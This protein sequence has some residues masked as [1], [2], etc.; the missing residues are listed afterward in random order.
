[1]TKT[2]KRKVYLSGAMRGIPDLNYPAFTHAQR[3]V[4]AYFDSSWVIVNPADLPSDTPAEDALKADY[5]ALVE[6]DAIAF[7]PNWHGSEGARTEYAIARSLGLKPLFLIE[8]DGYLYEVVET[9]WSDADDASLTPAED[10]AW[11][12]V[13]GKRGTD[14]GPPTRDFA[15]T[16]KMWSGVL[17]VDVTPVQVA[18][19]MICLKVSRL[20]ESN[21]HIDS[22]IDL[23]GYAICGLSVSKEEA[24]HA[25]GD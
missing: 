19:M 2:P 16:A 11:R 25:I 12:K 15:R 20:S 1:M 23:S 14:Y 9:I 22:W 13:Y 4:E 10:A 18:L 7:L 8:D 5:R 17:G 24:K 6:C 21:T 3:S